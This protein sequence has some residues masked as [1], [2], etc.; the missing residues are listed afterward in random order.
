MIQRK[1]IILCAPTDYGFAETIR[2]ALLDQ[3]FIV[4]AFPISREPFKYK[5][6]TDRLYNCYRKVFFN[7]YSYKEKLKHEAQ[8]D[9]LYEKLRSFDEVADYALFIRPDLYPMEFVEAIKSKAIKTVAYQWDGLDRFPAVYNYID[10]FDRFF[11]FD[12]K[13][14]N[15][16]PNLLPLTNFFIP[17][18]SHLKAKDK[19]YLI[20]TFDDYRFPLIRQIKAEFEKIEYPHH[21]S[22]VTWNHNQTERLLHAGLLVGKALDYEQNLSEVQKYNVL[23]DIHA[24]IHNGLSFRI[25]EALCY[26]KRLIT[27]NQAVKDYDFYHPDNIFIWNGNNQSE[28]RQ[29]LVRDL[30]PLPSELIEKYSFANWIKYV[31]DIKGHT[32]ITL[33]VNHKKKEDYTFA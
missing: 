24:P 16:H 10:L 28:L 33:P 23:I 6:L 2:K 29:F 9:K 12:K 17:K 3:G 7:D 20:A 4:Y 32:E 14:L 19:A 27:T 31:L 30:V 22:V 11:V 25:F 5:R 21:F 1:T 15:K 26:G 8:Y 13:D 18:I